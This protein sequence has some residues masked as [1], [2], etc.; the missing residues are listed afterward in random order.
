MTHK[1][2][3]F[4]NPI[5]SILQALCIIFPYLH[6]QPG[7]DCIAKRNP[8]KNCTR[9]RTAA[10]NLYGRQNIGR[11]TQLIHLAICSPECNLYTRFLIILF[12]FENQIALWNNVQLVTIIGNVLFS[13]YMF[14]WDFLGFFGIF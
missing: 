13:Y 1:K 12:D 8:G 9:L 10:R 6:K 11:Y 2:S 14:F 7:R 5:F 3:C 4:Q